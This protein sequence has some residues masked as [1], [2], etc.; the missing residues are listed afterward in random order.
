MGSGVS[1]GMPWSLWATNLARPT[2]TQ[3][4]REAAPGVPVRHVPLCVPLDEIRPNVRI[5][6]RGH[7]V[8][9]EV[10]SGAPL[11]QAWPGHEILV[12]DAH[13]DA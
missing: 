5:P 8:R 9:G 1:R 6:H 7:N 3:P 11:R 4:T 13:F 12:L 2:T 10:D